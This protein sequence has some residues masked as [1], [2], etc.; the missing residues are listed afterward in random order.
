M[1][2]GYNTYDTSRRGLGGDATGNT[3]GAEW[4]TFVSAGRD[5]HF[6]NL[7]IGPAASLQYTNAYVTGFSE[8]GSIAPL[9]IHS[10]S[11]ESLRTDL[12]FKASYLWQIRAVMAVPYLKAAWEHE[13]KY[14]A[15]P[16]TAGLADVPG[17]AAT[18]AGPAEGHDSAVLSAGVAVNW[19]PRVSTYAEYDG[20]LGRARYDSNAITGGVQVSW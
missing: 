4:S 20:Q 9:Q 5:F 15:L 13:F 6:G 11:E 7:T 8:T 2:G 12:G 17:P 18:F 10:D 3:D 16:V 19:T 14:S 1:F